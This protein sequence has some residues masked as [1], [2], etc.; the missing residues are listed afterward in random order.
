MS[1]ITM[2]QAPPQEDV[3]LEDFEGFAIDRLQ[4]GQIMHVL[5]IPNS[6]QY[7][8]C[9]RPVLRMI[10]DGRLSRK[11]EDQLQV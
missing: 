1:T 5:V 9:Y 10:E 8:V 3:A 6:S 4:G 2:Y 11:P 7:T